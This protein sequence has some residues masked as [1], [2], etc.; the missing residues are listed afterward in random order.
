MVHGK[1][2]AK[3]VSFAWSQHRILSIDSK[4]RTTLHVPIIDIKEENRLLIDWL[5]LTSYHVISKFRSIK[6]DRF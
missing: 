4:I 1:S 3:E 5:A 2:T 6:K